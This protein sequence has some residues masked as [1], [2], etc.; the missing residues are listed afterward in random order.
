M[1]Q[2][3][4]IN[5]STFVAK[6]L[7]MFRELLTGRYGDIERVWWDHYPDG[8]GMRSPG[9]AVSRTQIWD[10]NSPTISNS[11]GAPVLNPAQRR[12]SIQLPRAS[13]P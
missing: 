2:H 4:K 5:G 8:C 12:V 11:S 13:L 1:Q 9:G 6:E 10:S 7:A 3:P